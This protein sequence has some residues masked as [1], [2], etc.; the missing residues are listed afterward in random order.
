MRIAFLGHSWRSAGIPI[1]QQGIWGVEKPPIWSYRF[2]RECKLCKTTP[3][4]RICHFLELKT[5]VTSILGFFA[6]SPFLFL[7]SPA[8]SPLCSLI[9]IQGQRILVMTDALPEVPA[10]LIDFLY[11]LGIG[12]GTTIFSEVTWD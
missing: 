4:F 8:R 12:L 1:S 11:N 9:Y 5:R 6:F 10:L 7:A 2:F 3:G